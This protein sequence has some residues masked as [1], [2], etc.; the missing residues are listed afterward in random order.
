VEVSSMVSSGNEGK[1]V[2]PSKYVVRLARDMIFLPSEAR[3]I[4]I[5]V[6]FCQG[7]V[8]DNYFKKY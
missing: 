3:G 1:V 2:N 7:N 8:K 6:I 4:L 5:K